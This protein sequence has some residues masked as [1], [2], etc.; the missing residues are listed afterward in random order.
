METK[1]VLLFSGGVDSLVC[2]FYMNQPKSVYVNLDTKY[3]NKEIENINKFKQLI[4]DFNCEIIEGINLGQFEEGEKAF[5][6][7]RN[8]ILS[9][10][11]NNFGNRIILGGIEDD[12]VCDKNP[13]AFEAMSK[14]L[15]IVNEEPVEIYS[16]FWKM[17]KVEIIDWFINNVENADDLLKL[18]ISCY[19][20]EEGQC[21]NCP[22]CFRKAIAMSA[23]DLDISFFNKD[24]T[25]YNGIPEYLEKFKNNK[26]SE[27]RTKETLKVLKNWGYEI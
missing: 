6:K 5:V 18:S 16:P 8:L 25:K 3:S 14:C 13:E 9:C 22:S 17:S 21:G 2:W 4:P 26:Y 7:N 11:A 24:I 15:S 19:S 1:D 12:K 10:I 27:K 20:E 23:L